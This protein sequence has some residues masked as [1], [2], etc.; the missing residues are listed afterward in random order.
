M[1]EKENN[2]KIDFKILTTEHLIE[3][4]EAETKKVEPLVKEEIKP[5]TVIKIEAE[6][7]KKEL[8]K[9]IQE[10][11]MTIELKGVTG[12][13]YP[14]KEALPQA[15]PETFPEILSQKQE[16]VPPQ[17]KE[18]PISLKP[19]E[20]ILEKEPQPKEIPLE[21]KEPQEPKIF[22]QPK[23]PEINEI[24]KRETPK[25]SKEEPSLK[26]KRLALPLKNVLLGALTLGI[27]FLIIFLKPYEKLKIT[28]PQK[29]TKE[30]LTPP[31]PTTTLILPQLTTSAP[32]PT[33]TPPTPTEETLPS[34]EE[35]IISEPKAE[36]KFLK[37]TFL[38][39]S[40]EFSFINVF[41]SKE[42]NL[43]ELSFAEF[44]KAINS[45]L[46]KQEAAGSIFNLE[47]TFNNQKI[48]FN[49]VFDYF[50]KPS[51]ISQEKINAFKDEFT[52]NFAFMIYY[53]Y[54]RKYPILIFEIK[55]PSTVRLFNENWE[56]TNMAQD[57]KNLF[58]NLDPGK[59][60][61]NYFVTRE[62]DS[63]AYRV[64]YFDNNLKII[65]T[66]TPNYLIYSSTE[67]GLKSIASQLK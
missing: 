29:E 56:K 28:S 2:K 35:P 30:I 54:T 47:I 58:F 4:K 5:E 52:G 22:Y 19:K 26:R 62:I 18:P 12:L 44:E 55:N 48:P 59:P 40:K 33:P 11:K 39:P 9:K 13:H 60:L 15:M 6:E 66:V 17:I 20:E 24:I 50:I 37:Q 49:F 43:K 38:Y 67:N 1:P 31:Q 65:W 45:L 16:P 61:R 27:I 21:P 41:P 34:K 53:G 14:K 23:K 25:E 10:E 57:L 64:I 36:E 46:V 7:T 63:L 32:Q 42:I 8:E 51:K 3:E